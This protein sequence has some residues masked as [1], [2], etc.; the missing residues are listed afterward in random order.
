MASSAS[1]FTPDELAARAA[2]DAQ[3]A[4]RL[5]NLACVTDSK[6]A[7][8]L[9]MLGFLGHWRKHHNVTQQKTLVEYHFG[10][11]SER[12]PS[13]HIG[14]AKEWHSGALEKADPCHPLVIMM[15]AHHCYDQ[16]NAMQK[17]GVSMRLVITGKHRRLTR[18]KPGPEHQAMQ[19]RGVAEWTDD[20]ALAA[21]CA[22][23]GIPVLQITGGGRLHRYG[24]P[25]LGY[26]LLNAQGLPCVYAA[27]DCLRRAPTKEDPFRLALEDTEPLHPVCLAYDVLHYRA[28]L[29]AL[30]DG[31]SPLLIVEDDG[32]KAILS[33]N[34][35]GRVMDAL[36]QRFGAP[37]LL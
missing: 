2:S 13:L 9:I 16:L 18:Y 23:V 20:F 19:L 30:I 8:A 24:L 28:Q 27:A 34:Y 10:P 7:S 3:E 1:T 4:V 17:D 21:A 5:A 31:K 29:K 22:L 15:H 14:I 36:T 33:P 12:F 11:R 35:T 6:L 32:L 37:P 25:A 26:E